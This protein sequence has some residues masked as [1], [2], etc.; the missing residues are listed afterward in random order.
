LC[1][2]NFLRLTDALERR[3]WLAWNDLATALQHKHL[4]NSYKLHKRHQ[5]PVDKVHAMG[6]MQMKVPEVGHELSDLQGR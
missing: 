6:K 3:P 1:I 5:I 2:F 4:D